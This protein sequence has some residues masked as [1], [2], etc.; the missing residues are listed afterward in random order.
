MLSWVLV[1]VLLRLSDTSD[2]SDT[3]YT[4]SESV[5]V[6][7]PVSAI[8]TV[9]EKYVYKYVADFICSFV[10]FLTISIAQNSFIL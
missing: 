9:P 7:F 4:L 1:W 6:A 2:F 8:S 5:F 10:K 3:K